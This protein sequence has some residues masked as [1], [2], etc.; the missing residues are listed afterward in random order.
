MRSVT[1]AWS[2]R[3]GGSS[4]ALRSR[5]R[6]IWK[7][8][9]RTPKRF[10]MLWRELEDE[11]NRYAKHLPAWAIL[12]EGLP[13]KGL[14]RA[15][16]LRSGCAATTRA[17]PRKRSGLPKFL[18]RLQPRYWENSGAPAGAHQNLKGQTYRKRDS[19]RILC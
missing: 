12:T 1:P 13:M 3:V 18:I 14:V 4:T 8:T 6:P 19:C 15:T 16:L 5:A 2:R 7:Q 9:A 11:W 17:I 10:S